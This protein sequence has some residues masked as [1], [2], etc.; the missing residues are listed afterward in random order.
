MR[1]PRIGIPLS[2]DDR[3]RWRSGRSY[4]Y[5]DRSYASAIERAGGI[6]LQLPIQDDPASLIVE[7]D[8]LLI[9]GGDDLPAT[10]PLP[11][12]IEA[13]LD[14]VPEAQLRFDESLLSAALAGGRPVLGI[15]YGMQLLARFRGGE[16]IADLPHARP[17]AGDHRLAIDARHAISIESKSRLSRILDAATCSVNSLHHQAVVRAGRG[18]RAVAFAADGVIEAI[19]GDESIAGWEL[20][21]QWHPEKMGEA[22]SARL[23]EAFIAACARE[24]I[25]ERAGASSG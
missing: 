9:P 17:E 20:G 21:V 5:L 1:R 19:E 13:R 14:L 16:L 22:S 15:C 18:H 10:E 25:D 8:G 23:F 4:Y 24:R 6:P 7:L 3:G 12:D 2:L 11:E